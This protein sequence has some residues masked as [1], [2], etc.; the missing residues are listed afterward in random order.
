MLFA[1]SFDEYFPLY[2]RISMV[3]GGSITTST[4]SASGC[5]WLLLVTMYSSVTPSMAT[6]IVMTTSANFCCSLALDVGGCMVGGFVCLT[7][8]VS[9]VE[10][11]NPYFNTGPTASSQVLVPVRLSFSPIGSIFRISHFLEVRSCWRTFFGKDD[12]HIYSF[13]HFD[14]I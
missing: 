8:P 6:C 12:E 13:I 3:I 5:L 2:Y 10:T 9:R 4:L 1:I 14:I 7:C 11:G